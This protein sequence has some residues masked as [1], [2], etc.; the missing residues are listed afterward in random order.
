M[1]VGVPPPSYA[2]CEV[3]F[4]FHHIPKHSHGWGLLL[5]F[6]GE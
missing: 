2:P 6:T 5:V 3:L 4:I 1:G